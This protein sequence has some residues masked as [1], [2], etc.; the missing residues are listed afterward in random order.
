MLIPS[1]VT[2]MVATV[3]ALFSINT[4]EEIVKVAMGCASALSAL[5]TLI[6]A[7]WFIKLFIVVI[8]FV[9]D[10]LNYWPTEKPNN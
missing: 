3:A 7:P 8:P 9:L 1:I 6:F 2:L 10:K 5:L 4:D